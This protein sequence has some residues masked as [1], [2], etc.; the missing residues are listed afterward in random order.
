MGEDGE[1]SVTLDADPPQPYKS[2]AHTHNE[3]ISATD[4]I[5]TYSVFSIGDLQYIGKRLREEEI[6]SSEFVAFLA[7]GKGTRL[8]LTISNSS[9]TINFF[10]YLDILE[11]ALAG[12]VQASQELTAYFN[13]DVDPLLKKYYDK[14]DPPIAP[15]KVE[16][17]DN[18]EVLL[19]FLNFMKE[20]DMG[21]DIFEVDEAF[22]TFERLTV[23]ESGTQI[24]KENCND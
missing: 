13:A 6:V 8:A 22:E 9:K 16:N 3:F 15:I 14:D 4:T 18:D 1:S 21:L 11:E 23:N 5:Q 10:R 24:E 17:T 20:A 12:N 2:I 19:S 7:T